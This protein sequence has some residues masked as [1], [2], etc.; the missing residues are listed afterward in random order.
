MGQ[1]G[2]EHHYRGGL[3]RSLGFARTEEHQ[4]TGRIGAIPLAHFT[5]ARVVAEVVVAVGQADARLEQAD[6]M[7]PLV[8][9]IRR[10]A[11]GDRR[12]HR[13]PRQ[14]GDPRRQLRAIR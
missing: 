6:A 2:L 14:L 9:R 1:P 12:A 11:D 4:Q 3:F 13:H 5:S 8:A 7:A 10:N